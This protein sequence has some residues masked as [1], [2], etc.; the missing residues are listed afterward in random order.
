MSVRERAKSIIFFPCSRESRVRR[1]Y[2]IQKLDMKKEQMKYHHI[3]IPTKSPQDGET[4]LEE[5]DIHCTDH[6][7]SPYGIQWMRYGEKC[8]LPTIVKE[9]AHIAFEVEDLRKAIEGKEVIIEPNSPGEGVT[10]AFILENGV[11]VELLE[12]SGK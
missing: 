6:E 9:I 1:F 10:V 5:Y 3:G 4:Y 2:L 7:K 11:P 12:L 8:R